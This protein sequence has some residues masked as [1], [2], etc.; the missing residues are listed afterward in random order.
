MT[1]YADIAVFTGPGRACNEPNRAVEAHVISSFQHR[2][3]QLDLWNP[4]QRDCWGKLSFK[5]LPVV[6]DSLCRPKTKIRL[7]RKSASR[8][9]F[10]TYRLSTLECDERGG[11]HEDDG[12]R[13]QELLHCFYLLK[14]F[15]L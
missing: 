8:F 11:R 10:L 9:L 2:H 6:L 14:A 15:E 4:E 7:S 1:R 5:S 13:G 12:K 3:F